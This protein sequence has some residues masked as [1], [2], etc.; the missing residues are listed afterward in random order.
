MSLLNIYRVHSISFSPYPFFPFFFIFVFFL[1]CYSLVLYNTFLANFVLL[2]SLF[3]FCLDIF[4]SW[5]W[6]LRGFCTRARNKR[7][8][9]FFLSLSLSSAGDAF[10]YIYSRVCKPFPFDTCVSHPRVLW[11]YVARM[12]TYVMSRTAQ[13]CRPCARGLSQCTRN[14]M[15][16]RS[17][18]LSANPSVGRATAA[19]ISG[20]DGGAAYLRRGVHTCTHVCTRDM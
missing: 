14:A 9:S 11:V 10:R 19:L 3:L 20:G 13:K 6:R 2:R 1:F 8:F 17:P 18:S 16:S 4:L 5:F 12:Y 7:R 15:Y